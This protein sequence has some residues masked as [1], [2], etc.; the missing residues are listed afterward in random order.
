MFAVD[1]RCPAI[2]TAGVNHRKVQLLFGCAEF[3]E[4]LKRLVHN[5]IGTRTWAVHFVHHHDDLHA[6]R[7][8]FLGHETRL[9]HWT[10]DS[11]N[12]QQRAVH[13]REHALDLAAEVGVARCVDDV[14]SRALVSHSA[15]LCQNRDAAFAF[16]I[17]RVH[18]A[19]AHLFVRGECARLLKQAVNQRGFAVVNVSNDG[20]IA[21]T[22]VRAGCHE[23]ALKRLARNAPKTASI[24][25]VRKAGEENPRFY[26]DAARSDRAF[27]LSLPTFDE[28]A[29]RIHPGRRG[30]FVNRQVGPVK[31]LFG[32]EAQA[33]EILQRAV[34]NR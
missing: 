22:G 3:V 25:D 20:D 4:Q 24:P 16:D 33:H 23:R 21:K 9:R 2:E 30:D 11:V 29:A 18:H 6:E 14:D 10:F 8:R 17:V 5:P 7:E 34:H 31:F 32:I 13:H 26:C 1:E 19:L 12:Q 15:I 28:L 27:C